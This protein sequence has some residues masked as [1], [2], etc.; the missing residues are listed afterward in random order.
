MS[1]EDRGALAGS[2]FSDYLSG[3]EA[4]ASEESAA[5]LDAYSAHFKSELERLASAG[6]EVIVVPSEQLKRIDDA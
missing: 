1:R 6:V 2:K 3:A 4:S 5:L